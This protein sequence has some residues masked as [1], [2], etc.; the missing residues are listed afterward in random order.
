MASAENGTESNW[1]VLGS[2]I[3]TTQLAP[4][5]S[6]CLD[7]PITP[8]IIGT[9]EAPCVLFTIQPKCPIELQWKSAVDVNVI[10]SL[11]DNTLLH[12]PEQQA[13]ETEYS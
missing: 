11:R 6:K 4:R 8:C 12:Q 7:I 5:S 13:T 10:P 1:V 3:S 9:V 2:R